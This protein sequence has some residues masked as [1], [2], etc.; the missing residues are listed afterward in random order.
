MKTTRPATG[1]DAYMQDFAAQ[2]KRCTANE[3]AKFHGD[4]DPEVKRLAEDAKRHQRSGWMIRR[5]INAARAPKTPA[6]E[7]RP[8]TTLRAPRER[9]DR[10]TSSPSRAGP[11]DD[12]ES[13][14]PPSRRLCACGCRSDIS[15]RAPQARYLNETHGNADRQRRKRWLARGWDPGVSFRDGFLGDPYSRFEVPTYE[16]LRRRIEDGC[17]CNGHHIADG[18]DRHC[19]KCGH[20]RGSAAPFVG[21]IAAQ[22]AETRRVRKAVV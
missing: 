8:T 6:P 11:G 17:R 15:H 12:S 1:Y 2:I 16:Q 19:I 5:Q 10:R 4:D 13:S 21:F 18:E 14:E 22:S 7:L 20:R 3:R 9:R